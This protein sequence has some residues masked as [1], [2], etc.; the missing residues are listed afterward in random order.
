MGHA[1]LL[2]LALAATPP[3]VPDRLFTP[4]SAIPTALADVRTLPEDVRHE[5]L[6]FSA[7][8]LPEDD[9]KAAGQTLAFVVNS[10]SRRNVTVAPT[11]VAGSGGRLWR[12]LLSDYRLRRRDVE[13]LADLGSGRQPFPE[14]FFHAQVEVG[15]YED[16][17]GN[18]VDD[19]APGGHWVTTRH[20]QAQAPWLPRRETLAL[21]AETG[22]ES[23]VLRLDWF[24]YYALL[25]PRY[26]EL[27]G[28]DDTKASYERL[29]GL[30]EVGDDEETVEIGSVVLDSEVAGNNRALFRRASRKRHG[31]AYG[32]ESRDF[33]KSI[34]AQDILQDPSKVAG[35]AFET[36][37][38]LPNGLQFY[39]VFL[40]DG[41]RLD[42]AGIEFAHD[43]RNGFRSVEVE[44]RNCPCCHAAGVIPVDDDVRGYASGAVALALR[45]LEA[46]DRKKA[47]FVADR[48][49]SESVGDVILAD[50]SNYDA[51][52]RACNGLAAPANALQLRRLL[53][54]FERNRTLED[55]ALETG[56]PVV[57]V[58]GVLERSARAP[59]DHSV[60]GVLTKKGRVRYDQYFARG[61]SQLQTLL[62]QLPVDTPPPARRPPPK[63]TRTARRA[64]P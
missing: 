23:P 33:D 1:A 21:V 35:R 8:N 40:A 46:R 47:R 50:Q 20:R 54:A 62:S 2:A 59:L 63:D 9:L 41:K 5:A 34:E 60:M 32:W 13:R 49:F 16:D 10:L 39:G 30:E 43:G 44:I 48:Y 3:K 22:T 58:R 26:H 19:D 28:L 64:G 7:Y 42:R 24:C 36:I 11:P 31:R 53:L 45:D 57:T 12:V 4:A 29:A 6:Y 38:T 15:H 27:L 51:A 61:H 55:L 52:V 17:Y 37:Y 14:P 56:Y 25:E 18:R